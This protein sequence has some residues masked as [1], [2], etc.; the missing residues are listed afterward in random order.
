MNDSEPSPI[1]LKTI[2]GEW[3]A[4]WW[5]WKAAKY[6]LKL[7]ENKLGLYYNLTTVVVYSALLIEAYLNHVLSYFLKKNDKLQRKSPKSKLNK[8]IKKY[9]IEMPTNLRERFHV[10]FQ[11]RNELVHARTKN[12]QIGAA[13]QDNIEIIN[14]NRVLI[15]GPYKIDI[16]YAKSFFED[17]E[18]IVKC[19]HQKIEQNINPYLHGGATS[20]EEAVTTERNE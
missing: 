12:I 2:S 11:V 5:H 7:C 14:A 9:E 8:V 10:I 13:S 17:A 4:Y 3:R 16:K 20:Y 18:K 6:Y 15:A 1:I 19:I